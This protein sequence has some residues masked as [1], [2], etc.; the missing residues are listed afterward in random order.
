MTYN[1]VDI[2]LKTISDNHLGPT[3]CARFLYL[4]SIV[5]YYVMSNKTVNGLKHVKNN[6]MSNKVKHYI[7]YVGFKHLYELLNY[8]SSFFVK[9]VQML[10]EANAQMKDNIIKFLND[11]DGDNWKIANPDIVLPNGSAFIDVE[12]VQDLNDLLSE[13][14]RK[15]TPLKHPNGVI[16]KYLTP[17]WG[18]VALPIDV[19]ITKYTQIA[20][21]NFPTSE[22]RDAEIQDMLKTYLGLTN[23]Q[24]IVAEYFQGGQVTPPGIWNIWAKYTG[25]ALSWSDL[26]LAHFLYKLNTALFMSSVVCWRIKYDYFQARPIQEIR[27]LGQNDVT[28]WDG[29]LVNSSVWKPFQQSNNRT[30]PFP[31]YISGHSTFS[32]A[33]AVIFN[34][35]VGMPFDQIHFPP[36]THEH[37][38]MISSLLDNDYEKYSKTYNVSKWKQ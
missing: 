30:P 36:F 29:T 13:E 20:A 2:I 11:R 34:Q 33:A 3:Y 12:N 28:T 27:L 8:D 31:D 6:A 16:Q 5:I 18:D 35:Y 25:M 10:S 9:P 14:P 38:T 17:Y 15:W 21:D 19:N 32:S 22:S 23:Q 7:I 24:R 26:Q 37:A 4:T 1:W